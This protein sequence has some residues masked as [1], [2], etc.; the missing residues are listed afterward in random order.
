MNNLP[1]ITANPPNRNK[2]KGEEEMSRKYLTAKTKPCRLIQ[3][4]QYIIDQD[5]DHSI[6]TVGMTRHV[7][8]QG[9]TYLQ[10]DDVKFLIQLLSP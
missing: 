1:K 10:Q 4:F 6:L 2:N 3:E 9:H 8:H 5:M 7:S